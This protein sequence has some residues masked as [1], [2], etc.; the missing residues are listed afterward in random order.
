M[1]TEK[2]VEYQ[3]WGDNILVAVYGTLRQGLGNHGRLVGAELLST[4]QIEGFGMKD[5]GFPAI[6]DKK[7]G[8]ITIEVYRTISDDQ[9]RGLDALEGYRDGGTFYDR[10][11]VDTS[12]GKAWIYFMSEEGVS[13]LDP[14]KDGDYKNHVERRRK[15]NASS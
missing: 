11:L 6:Y 5:M 14:I 4:E 2:Q 12:Q 1:Y 7:G 8:E 13:H 3:P 15:A 9:R 10:K